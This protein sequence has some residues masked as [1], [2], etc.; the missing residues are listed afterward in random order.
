[1]TISSSAAPTARI[2]SP[3][4]VAAPVAPT[5]RPDR[6]W[7]RLAVVGLAI[8]AIMAILAPTLFLMVRKARDPAPNVQE[9]IASPQSQTAS[10]QLVIGPTQF[11]RGDP[12]P[13]ELDW[14]FKCFIPPDHLA[15]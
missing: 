1:D 9:K 12:E 3:S 8:I 14:G 13:G 7:R 4:G 5:Q 10:S 2:G 6:F 15:S 11:G